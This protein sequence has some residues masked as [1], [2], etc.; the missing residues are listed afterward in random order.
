MRGLVTPPEHVEFS[1]DVLQTLVAEAEASSARMKPS[2]PNRLLLLRLSG[3]VA[4]LGAKCTQLIARNR[5]LVTAQDRPRIVV[6]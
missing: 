4:L 6:P 3:M 2:N 1:A 5:Q